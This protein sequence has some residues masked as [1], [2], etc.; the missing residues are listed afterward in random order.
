MQENNKKKITRYRSNEIKR[1]EFIKS[2]CNN[3][4]NYVYVLLNIF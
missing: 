1:Y 2:M 4:K 3:L